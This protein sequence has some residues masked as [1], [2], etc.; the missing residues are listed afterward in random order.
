MNGTMAECWI[1]GTHKQIYPSGD[2]YSLEEFF[3]DGE[4]ERVKRRAME[5]VDNHTVYRE[6]LMLYREV[7]RLHFTLQVHLHSTMFRWHAREC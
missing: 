1:F 2:Y 7:Q 4:G 6:E 3:Y 5:T